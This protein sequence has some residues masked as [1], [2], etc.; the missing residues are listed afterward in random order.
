MPMEQNRHL[1][2]NQNNKTA[3]MSS[4]YRLKKQNSER[5]NEQIELPLHNKAQAIRK[6]IAEETG[7]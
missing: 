7:H 1:V 4:K 3:I 5:N 6:A 2:I